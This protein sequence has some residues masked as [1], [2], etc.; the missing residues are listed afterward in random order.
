MQRVCFKPVTWHIEMHHMR[1]F[2]LAWR[3]DFFVSHDVHSQHVYLQKES[4]PWFFVCHRTVSIAAVYQLKI[5]YDQHKFG[6]VL[7][8]AKR[9][10]IF[11]LEDKHAVI[12]HHVV[13]KSHDA[14][15]NRCPH[16]VHFNVPRDW[17]ETNSRH[18]KRYP[19][20]GQ[21]FRGRRRL[22]GRATSPSGARGDIF[23]V[24]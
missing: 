4:L 20:G 19:E 16:E 7:S 24:R 6:V 5:K 1:V 12:E 21:K 22:L 11:L 8:D 13:R 18:Q 14:T 23:I 17:S 9:P 3:H 2:F 10:V 15:Q